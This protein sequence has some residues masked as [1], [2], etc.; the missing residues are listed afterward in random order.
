MDP[1]A[2]ELYIFASIGVVLAVIFVALLCDFLK[3][4][5]EQLREHNIELRVRQEERERFY[6][7]PV[8]RPERPAGRPHFAS[9]GSAAE[10]TFPQEEFRGAGLERD[11]GAGLE[12]A[13]PAPRPSSAEHG[14]LPGIQD[15]TVLATLMDS[16]Q[17]FDG[18]IVAVGINDHP[19]L[20][21][22][23]LDALIQSLLLPQDAA[24]RSAEGEYLLVFPGER[25]R[26]AQHRLYHV[27]E[28]LWD[29]QLRKAGELRAALSW[30]GLE[31]QE[32]T[33]AEAIATARERMH[34]HQ[35]RAGASPLV[36]PLRRLDFSA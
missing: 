4:D 35:R 22:S 7:L 27:S 8:M 16:K 12:V 32:E 21:A 20:E 9:G 29:Y 36:K 15:A 33:F 2:P 25:G 19:A 23:S 24:F 14:I 28:Q 18:V 26:A 17:P 13:A 10:E 30:G 31:A 1:A 11:A 5:N 34:Q 3:G 6:Q